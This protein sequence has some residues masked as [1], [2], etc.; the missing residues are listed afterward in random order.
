MAQSKVSKLVVMNAATAGQKVLFFSPHADD[1][2]IAAGG[3]IAQSVINGADVTI[4]MVTDSDAQGIEATRY[5]E[6]K[7]A[8]G[9]L[10]VPE[11]NLV[12]LGFPDSKLDSINQAVLQAALQQQIDKYNPDIIIYPSL[13]DY[14]SDHRAIGRAIESIL[15]TE[16]MPITAYNYLVHYELDYP[17]PRGLVPADYIMPPDHLVKSEKE[18]LSF[19]LSPSI[20]SCK[21]KAIFSYQSQIHSPELSGLMKGNIRKN[22]IFAIPN[23]QLPASTGTSPM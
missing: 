6:F 8:T 7:K 12:F 13:Y 2:S 5:A 10:G 19:G 3:Y 21:E 20:E 23:L 18:W 15:K 22:E 11:S 1:E 9:I 16:S 17:K 4:I 14:N